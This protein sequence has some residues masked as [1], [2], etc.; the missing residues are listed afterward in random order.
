M[1]VI[2]WNKIL[3]PFYTNTHFLL[4]GLSSSLAQNCVVERT[5]LWWHSVALLDTRH[6]KVIN[7]QSFM[8]Q[9]IVSV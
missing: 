2:L 3:L 7:S 9:H 1:L 6:P 8:F 4:H 5:I